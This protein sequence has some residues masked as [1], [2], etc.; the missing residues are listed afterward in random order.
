MKQTRSLSEFTWC[1][2]LPDFTLRVD[3][4]IYSKT[5]DYF[6]LELTIFFAYT[7]TNRFEV[8]L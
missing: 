7:S 6:Y 3:K 2:K 8:C 1:P 5:Q 4:I